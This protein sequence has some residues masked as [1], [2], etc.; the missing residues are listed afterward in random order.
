VFASGQATQ[1]SIPLLP[2]IVNDVQL[3]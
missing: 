1:S 3:E 2:E